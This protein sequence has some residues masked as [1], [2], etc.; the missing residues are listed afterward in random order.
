VHAEDA[1]K[2]AT[3]PN[4]ILIMADDL[5]TG[6]VGWQNPKIR[7]PHLDRLAKEGGIAEFILTGPENATV[8]WS[9]SFGPE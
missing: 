6:H 8:E 7:T 5:G 4:I 9:V 3:K 1:P 2:S